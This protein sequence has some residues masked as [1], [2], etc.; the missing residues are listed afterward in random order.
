[1]KKQLTYRNNKNR[2]LAFFICFSILLSIIPL[3]SFDET[4]Q[5]STTLDGWS[6]N[7]LWSNFSH[8]YTW[9]AVE[10]T[11]KQPKIVVFYRTGRAT[12]DYAPGELTFTLPGIGN[13]NRAE[14][15]KATD[16][17]VEQSGSEWDYIWDKQNDTYTFTNRFSVTAE[18]RV[19]G[20]FEIMY[21]F[22]S[23]DVINGYTQTIE[24][25][26]AVEGEGYINLAPL[27]FAYTSTRDNYRINLLYEKLS[28][29]AWDASNKDYVWYTFTG[30]AESDYYS[31]GMN[32]RSVFV[33]VELDSVF[34]DEDYANVVYKLS[35]DTS[36]HHLI[37]LD[38]ENGKWGFYIQQER[39]GDLI[40]HRN[41]YSYYTTFEIGFEKTS[42]ANTVAEITM[43]LSAQY[44]DELEKITAGNE[45]A[46]ENYSKTLS[47]S[48][49]DYSFVPNGYIYSLYKRNQH[50]Q[51]NHQEPQYYVSRLSTSKLY[52]G[53]TVQFSIQGTARKDFGGSGSGGS[54]AMSLL[55]T[56]IQAAEI[57][58]IQPPDT[59]LNEEDE[60]VPLDDDGIEGNPDETEASVPDPAYEEDNTDEQLP[61]SETEENT[62][63]QEPGA[64]EDEENTNSN[65][66]DPASNNDGENADID[67]SA[68]IEIE[69][70]TQTLRGFGSG[71]DL[72][73]SINP[74][75]TYSLIIG[76]D[77]L[78]VYLNDGTIREL[79]D[80]E[81]DF[82][83]ITIYEDTEKIVNYTIYGATTQDALFSEYTYIASGSTATYMKHQLPTGY[84]AIY[85]SFNDLIGSYS[86]TIYA[87]VHIKIDSETE[88]L[89]DEAKQINGED[90]IV[91]YPY[92]LAFDER[93]ANDC[94]ATA[95]S[96]TYPT[97][98]L[99]P[100]DRTVFGSSDGVYRTYSNVW[101]RSPVVTLTALTE[102]DDFTKNTSGNFVTNITSSG[103]I[104]ADDAEELSRFSLIT[105]I[106]DSLK[107]DI[108]NDTITSNCVFYDI[109]GNQITNIDNNVEYRIHKQ[110]GKKII[111]AIF[112]FSDTPLDAAQ[113]QTVSIQYPVSLDYADFLAY[114]TIYNIGTYL[115]VQ[116]EGLNKIS[117]YS[118]IND[119]YDYDQD[120][121]ANDKMASYVINKEVSDN[122]IEWREYV[123]KSVKSAYTDGYIQE[124]E[125]R[126]F[127]SAE[128]EEKQSLSDYSYR[129]EFGVGSAFVKNILFYDKLE[130]ATDLLGHVSEWQGTFQSVDTSYV[131]SLGA[132]ATVY[133]ST[134]D[135]ALPN[136][137]TPGWTTVCPAD[138]ST[139]KAIAVMLDTSDCEDGAIKGGTL[140]YVIVNMRAPSDTSLV[141]KAAINNYIANFDSYDAEGTFIANDTLISTSNTVTLFNSIGTVRLQKVDADGRARTIN[142]QTVYPNLSGATLMIYDSNHD[143]IFDTPKEMNN[144]GRLLI[145]GVEAG[146]YY[147]EEITAPTGYQLI[148]GLHEFTIN[149]EGGT[150]YIENH[151]IPG[152]IT[153]VKQDADNDNAPVP[154]A[155]VRLYTENNEIVTTD[156]NN[157]YSI[158]GAKSEFITDANGEVT[159]TGLPW[160]TYYFEETVAPA[161][162][163][164]ASTTVSA[165][166]DREHLTVT[167]ILSEREFLSSVVLTKTDATSGDPVKG[168]V[169]NLEKQQSD[170][171]WH[172]QFSNI[173]TNLVG[174]IVIDNLTFGEY[175]FVEIASA[176]GYVLDSTPIPFTVNA[177]TVNTYI[178]VQAENVRK[179][180][181]VQL[182][183]WTEDRF[184]LENAEYALFAGYPIGFYDEDYEG[185]KGVSA[186]TTTSDNI[187]V[188]TTEPLADWTVAAWDVYT[189][190]ANPTF[191]LYRQSDGKYR[192]QPIIFASN[193]G[194]TISG[195]GD[196]FSVTNFA[197]D[198]YVIEF[199]KDNYDSLN[200]LE[201][202]IN[203]V[204]VERGDPIAE[205][206]LT[207]ASGLT[208]AVSGLSWGHYYFVEMNA[209][210]GYNIALSPIEFDVNAE[211]VEKT[212]IVSTLDTKLTGSVELTK[213]DE[214]TKSIPLE[215]AKFNLYYDN[216]TLVQENL[217]TDSNGKIFVDDLEWGNYYLEEIE[218]PT[219]Y[220]LANKVRFSVNID[221]CMI[222]Q[223][224][225]CYDPI[226]LATIIVN[227]EINEVYADFGTP[228]FI[229]EVE[230]TDLG[231]VHHKWI[232]SVTMTRDDDSVVFGNVPYGTYTVKEVNTSRY[233]IF[234]VTGSENV[235]VLNGGIAQVDLTA[236]N[237]GEVN[238]ENKIEQYEKFSHV[239][240]KINIIAASTKPTGITVNYIGPNPIRSE[241][242]SVYTFTDADF[243]IKVHYDDGTN[244]TLTL[245]DITLDY[246][247]VTGANNASGTGL[248]ITASYSEAGVN[249]QDQFSVVINLQP[250]EVYA[251][252]Y[253]DGE[254][255]FQL[256]N[257]PEEGR[258]AIGVYSGIETRDFDDV[259]NAPWLSQAA[260]IETV[261]FD[262]P[263]KP[264]NMTAWFKNC[265]NLTTINRL[266]YVD[267]SQV[268]SMKDLFANSGITSITMPTL[269]T[270]QVNNFS[271]MFK[272]CSNLTSVD[273]SRLNTSSATDM[274]WMFDGCSALTTLNLSNLNTTRVRKM[275]NMFNGCSAIITI[276]V[277]DFNTPSL[278]NLNNM[279]SNCTSLTTIYASEDFTV[280]ETAMGSLIFE[281]DTALIGGAGTQYD[282]SMTSKDMAHIDTVVDPGYF[283]RY[284]DSGQP[285]Y[286]ILYSDG[287]LEFQR[288]DTPDLTGGRTVTAA[289]TNF[290][291][292]GTSNPP[293]YNN[294]TNI[295]TINFK[296]AVMPRS[297]CS[298]FSGC[299][300]LT[301]INNISNLD[302]SNVTDISYMFYNCSSLT[303]L[304][305][306][307]FD[308]SKVADMRS[309]LYSCNKLTS[310]DV[311]GLDTSSVWGMSGMFAYCSGLTSLDVSGFNTSKV[312]S[313]SYMFSGC[314]GLTSLDLSGFDTS[315]VASMNSMF[316]GCS[317]L[318][319]LD[320]SG[321]DTSKVADMIY[322]FSGCSKLT[323]LDVTG[324]DTSS[325][326]DM[327]EMFRACSGLTSLD[328]SGFNTSKVKNMQSMFYDC[329]GL[330]SLDVS[331]FNTSKVTNMNGMFSN[332]SGLTNLDVMNFDT[333]SVTNMGGMFSHCDN[334]T[335]LDLSG[336]NTS[337]VTSMSYMFFCCK[338]LVTIYV[339]SS[340]DTTKVTNSSNMFFGCTSLIGGNGTIFNSNL[341]DATYAKIDTVDN[342][343]YFTYKESPF[344]SSEP[345][346]A[347]LYSNGLLEF[348]RGDTPDL[349]G[350][351][352]VTAAY[353]NF[354]NTGTSNPP[355]YNN[356]TNIKTI[357]FKDAVMPR[358]CCSWFSGCSN[359]TEINNI[360]NLDTSNVTD[361]SKM[362]YS[363]SGLTS[364]DVSGFNTSKVTSMSDMFSGCSK[365]TSLDVSGFDTSKVGNMDGMFSNC[366]KLTSLDVSDFN[367]SSVWGMSSMFSGCRSLTSLDLS[368]FD[369][370]KVTNMSYMFNSCSSL[371]SLDL[372]G[373]D[374]SKV[375]D[376]SYMFSGCSK[377]T[378]LDVSGFDT[379]KVTKMQGMF[380][381]C[382]KL[383][384]LDVSD[385][386]TSKVTNMDG[387]FSSCYALTS[388]DLSGFN[389]S[390]VT[391]MSY[392]FSG[393]SKLTSLDVSGFDTSKVTSMSSM[394]SGC[395][396]LT[397]LDVSGF[398]TSKV[399]SMSSMFSGCSGLTSLDVSDFNTS[400]VTSMSDMFSG[401]KSLVTIYVSSSFDTTKV[402]NSSNMFFG[403]TSLIGGNGTRYKAFQIDK[404]YARIDTSGNPGYFTL[405]GT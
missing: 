283:S 154:G 129:L 103:T 209:P 175:R 19:T 119:T 135:S 134:S 396:K 111:E 397:S 245:S 335:S 242:E 171:S 70:Q 351:R 118:V 163:E 357:N 83:Y 267:A 40:D 393:C 64:E 189:T 176:T 402:T 190:G 329:S 321:F 142:G 193:G 342:A 27:T 62:D 302:T 400:N 173:K 23:R 363:C 358:S 131:E 160:G 360:S 68:N 148:T 202:S 349:T 314:S 312:T 182:L 159:I 150:I 97:N 178:N 387:M 102:V 339:S 192:T 389:T 33:T 258:T 388:L 340:F 296:D 216:G 164:I 123:Y 394:F 69:P 282:A 109:N 390:K 364:L 385:F 240:Q 288:G 143:P 252:L 144:T 285:L 46:N 191:T 378:S 90:H 223:Q 377:L 373:F 256:G 361:I 49:D 266:D 128:S 297:C 350:G 318:T 257:A 187:T 348:Q 133:Y 352:T 1:M 199:D 137:G 53:Y 47:V 262:T 48:I 362:F 384:S 217:I 71:Q 346:C 353:T 120:G 341:I 383:T 307:G 323:S 30:R 233:Y 26:F 87:G 17:A 249:M 366:S 130:T 382:S 108:D 299:S 32:K 327:R 381:N 145:S 15:V 86:N 206:L 248:T 82:E 315:K 284:G 295:K 304:N 311:S 371:T 293:W 398:D 331:D 127:N 261:T 208:R 224:L 84:K 369:T 5:Y 404:T 386:N 51:Y 34:S 55:C 170:S 18:E 9:D 79:T 158:S 336:F 356:R 241:T 344:T 403:C 235:T 338:A 155:T 126:I 220:G 200:D 212:I 181:T 214:D 236:T 211:T 162:Y 286:A 294:R 226:A 325:V 112:D 218:A 122:A 54:S 379:S 152:T 238:F 113:T 100:R 186:G 332:C 37:K 24:P 177:S 59:T 52:E 36:E 141:G 110:D 281:N 306:T 194:F 287:L 3:S 8:D 56:G 184:R 392:M 138:K 20:G 85:V 254:L 290:L 328:V 93:G 63:T 276:D 365:L 347:I 16:I 38:N 101:L 21:S 61:E 149:E 65:D 117:G 180:G 279:F 185:N 275:N 273:I 44:D 66:V 146:T 313:M 391:S 399:T 375:T 179:T 292:T 124:A 95:Y 271:G 278:Q 41:N 405:A 228:T 115:T 174:E 345:L 14:L 370:S 268:N 354:L 78:V 316:S 265:S 310:L 333:S 29:T 291:N 204:A 246:P 96:G 197:P 355:W 198:K 25:T 269:D 255:V 259:R 169:F 12:R 324:F 277:T 231:G 227:K 305:V 322:M 98:V 125:T 309:M 337:K 42:L 301:E 165:S 107:I 205:H 67:S 57:E 116:D 401:C 201:T 35:G 234:N 253:D 320:L 151:R 2:F 225:T 183:K 244:R 88:L 106:P 264:K 334:L 166:V 270:R 91:N 300:N 39:R 213:L 326:T 58:T 77:K 75:E 4:K 156:V 45:N 210:R 147:W 11:G 263:I 76:D 89:K 380:S 280:P 43:E 222:T 140:T 207:D 73:Q 136:V 272:N 330:T 359:L 157:V 6:V 74:G 203:L 367:T 251:I 303:S 168:A 121:L 172:T 229:F 31:R 319:S 368:D 239:N 188:T 260:A 372:S 237:I 374:T 28:A 167:A 7:V 10:Y 104:T 219:G 298:W 92:L 80:D 13:A 196:S 114:G 343:G 317:K 105:V 221:T 232:K 81:Y 289:Y 50:E 99:L 195:N 60:S 132:K 250:P 308:T 395:S 230:G 274:S 153:L 139:V 161:G 22:K 243:E 247:R 94:S 215:G 376:I 72:L